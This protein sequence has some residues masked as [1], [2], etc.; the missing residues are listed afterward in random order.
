MRVQRLS[1]EKRC[2][3]TFRI[4]E[5][6]TH[7]RP[8]RLTWMLYLHMYIFLTSGSVADVLVHHKLKLATLLTGF[9]VF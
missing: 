4:L 1:H 8:T 9:A 5:L 2:A 7:A 3:M 6:H